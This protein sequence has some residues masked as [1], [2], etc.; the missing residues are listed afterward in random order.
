MEPGEVA[1]EAEEAW[2]AWEGKMVDTR[3]FRTDSTDN[4]MDKFD[5]RTDN[6]DR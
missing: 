2:E 6:F 5:I 4:C 1:S 3:V